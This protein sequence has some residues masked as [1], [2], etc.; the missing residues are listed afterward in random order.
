MIIECKIEK[1]SGSICTNIIFTNNLKTPPPS[2]AYT[3]PLWGLFFLSKNFYI[4]S[5]CPC[6][7]PRNVL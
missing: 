5:K 2:L 3:A 6:L 1:N 7:S 4:F